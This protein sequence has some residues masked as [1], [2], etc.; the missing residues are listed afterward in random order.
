MATN[1][2]TLLFQECQVQDK[3][4][5]TGGLHLFPHLMKMSRIVILG[6]GIAGTT[7]A[8]YIRKISDEEIVMISGESDYFYSRPSLMYVFMGHMKFEHTQPYENDFWANNRI[9]LKKAWVE[10]IAFDQ[11]QLT[12]ADGSSMD[13]DRL[14]LATGSKPNFFNWPGQDAKGVQGLY[15]LQDLQNMEA[16]AA[17]TQR[18]VIVGGGLIGVEMAEMYRSRGIA[19]TF[20]VREDRFWGSVLDREEGEMIAQHLVEDHHVDLRVNTE[21]K[22]I[23]SDAQGRVES[24]ITTAGETIQCQAVGLCTGVKP[25]IDF[26]RNSGLE[27]DRGI[28]VD[29][30]LRTNQ[31]DVFA[32][33]DCAQLRSPQS[34]R[35]ALEQVWYTGRMMGKLVAANCTGAHLKYDPGIWFNSAKFFDIEYQTYGSL[36]GL[37][38]SDIQQFFW[39][40]PSKPITFRMAFHKVSKRLLALTVFGMRLRHELADRWIKEERSSEYVLEHFNDLIFDPELFEQ[41]GVAILQLYNA[42]FHANV[43]LSK[44]SWKNILKLVQ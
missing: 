13:Y 3:Q 26:L 35:R 27:I 23:V 41:H 1:V 25:N 2:I 11:K 22:E 9:T 32:I 31:P 28:L 14:I 8:R 16:Y 15:S 18:A 36:I 21:L 40:H 43:K 29:D 6:N 38:S 39:K 4:Y 30:Q 12:F 33:G 24:I 5:R 20:L 42:Q 34:G 19:V 10:S 44:K 17:S 7:A 37:E